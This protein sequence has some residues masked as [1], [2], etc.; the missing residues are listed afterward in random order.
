LQLEIDPD[1]P[2]TCANGVQR[3]ARFLGVKFEK[4]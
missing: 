2:T 1:K 3:A 4:K